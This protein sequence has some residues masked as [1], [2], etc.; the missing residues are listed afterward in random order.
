MLNE[1]FGSKRRI[2]LEEF[3]RINMEVTSEMFL[4]ILILLQNQLP[5][6][7]N[8]YRYQKNFEKYMNNEEGGSATGGRP[9][10]EGK[11][12]TIAS[13]VMMSNSPINSLAKQVGINF[14]PSGTKNLLA[15]AA[16]NPSAAA[17]G[18]TENATP[19]EEGKFD[20]SNIRSA[21]Q[22]QADKKARAL[23]MQTL[24]EEGKDGVNADD[25]AALRLPNAVKRPKGMTL[26]TDPNAPTQQMVMSPTSFL[27]G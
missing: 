6:T 21:K 2:N 5:C 27:T 8:F 19:N 7:E 10:I 22:V 25:A 1:V 9:Q 18:S 15:H 17:A 26:S 11:V 16:K 24:V 23:E 12:Q 13:P 14:N 20:I 3:K 4:S